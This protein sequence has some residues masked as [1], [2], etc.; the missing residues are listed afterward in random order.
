MSGLYC[1]ELGFSPLKNLCRLTRSIIVPSKAPEDALLYIQ[2]SFP[3]S[4]DKSKVH[5]SYPVQHV[6]VDWPRGTCEIIEE[7]A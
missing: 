6:M 2:T 7:T 3:Q 1:V 5:R 4:L